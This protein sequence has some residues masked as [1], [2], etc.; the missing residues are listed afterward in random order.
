MTS[1]SVGDSAAG[2]ASE[3]RRQ[4]SNELHDG[5]LQAL[6]GIALKLKSIES[7]ITA[8]PAAAVRAIRD[9]QNVLIEEQRDI[10]VL[11]MGLR[12]PDLGGAPGSFSERFRQLIRRV[13]AV[14]DVTIMATV[15]VPDGIAERTRAHEVLRIVQEAIVNAVRHG[16]ARIVRVKLEHRD[17]ALRLAVADD[18]SGFSFRGDF[19]DHAL[20]TQRIGPVTLKARVKALT[21]TMTI[22]SGDDG[23]RLEIVVP[24]AAPMEEP[25]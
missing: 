8:N 20:A 12:E 11:M 21:G 25:E 13:E 7:L 16:R 22:H 24:I 6:T 2:L 18:G 17:A 4:I 15:E 10:R 23:V 14:W 9:V 19:D 3:D 1:P 5:L